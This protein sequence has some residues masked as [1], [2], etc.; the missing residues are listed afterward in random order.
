MIRTDLAEKIEAL[1]IR[2]EELDKIL[3]KALAGGEV[4]DE[5]QYDEWLGNRFLPNTVLI[6]KEQYAEMCVSALKIVSHV[7]ATD[8]GA[9]RQRDMGQLWAD[10]IRG[11]LG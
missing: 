9:S 4:K 8:Y 5:E 2:D 11:Y 10:M 7:A 6:G 1:G 3:E